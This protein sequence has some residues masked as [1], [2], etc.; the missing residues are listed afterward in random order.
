MPPNEE[1]YLTPAL[2]DAKGLGRLS[3]TWIEVVVVAVIIVILTSLLLPAVRDARE[4]KLSRYNSNLK[5]IGLGIL[6]YEH[7]FKRYPPA[8]LHDSQG[9]SLHSWRSLILPFV[10]QSKA[11][12][13]IDFSRPWNSS[14]NV[15]AHRLLERASCFQCPDSR[16][17]KP[18]LSVYHA[19]AGEDVFFHP[20]RGRLSKEIIDPSELTVMIV[21]SHHRHSVPIMKPEDLSTTQL[22]TSGYPWAPSHVPD[23]FYVAMA[24][25]SLREI[26]K[27][28]DPQVFQEMIALTRPDKHSQ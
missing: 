27:S 22:C 25:C 5:A 10:E 23:K 19:S 13:S 3:L 7:F 4:A 11:F 18:G 2:D 28:T 15:E 16:K 17:A 1:P 9:K 26:S 21:E 24:D 14:E 8:Y 20:S 12:E 6:N